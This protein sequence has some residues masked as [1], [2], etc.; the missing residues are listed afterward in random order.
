MHTTQLTH[1]NTFKQANGPLHWATAKVTK[2]TNT[3]EVVAAYTRRNLAHLRICK[4]LLRVLLPVIFQF[5][6]Y[7]AAPRPHPLVPTDPSAIDE[8]VALVKAHRVLLTLPPQKMLPLLKQ[9]LAAV[10]RGLVNTVKLPH[11]PRSEPY[12]LLLPAKCDGNPIPNLRRCHI[13]PFHAPHQLRFPLL[14][15]HLDHKN[16][17]NVRLLYHPRLHVVVLDLVLTARCVLPLHLDTLGTLP[18]L[19]RTSRRYVVVGVPLPLTLPIF[20]L[21]LAHLPPGPLNHFL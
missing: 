2:V 17:L 7:L 6:H 14:L 4:K 5:L 8:S 15:P 20:L 13:K 3:T 11:L 1:S 16:R 19:K 9:P 12:R 21:I 10:M 18:I